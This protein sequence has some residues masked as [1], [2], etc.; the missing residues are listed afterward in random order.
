MLFSDAQA[1][2]GKPLTL[3]E[4][5]SLVQEV[6]DA[7]FP[8]L[9]DHELPFQNY[10]SD[11]YFFQ[12]TV[13]P[14]ELLRGRKKFCLDVNSELLNC[15]PSSEALKAIISHELSH[16][17]D[18]QSLPILGV[19]KL[20]IAYGVSKKYRRS[21]ERQT[22]RNTVLLGHGPGLIDYR[23]WLYERLSPKAVRTK[24]YYYLSPEEI[25]LISF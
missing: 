4:L 5:R 23:L 7:H 12:A 1:S 13:N 17:Q 10:E 25:A 6:R 18:Y 24:K 21:Y 19:A 2:C 15:P 14:G 3:P 9:S 16:F 20:G 22:D 8:A 11:S